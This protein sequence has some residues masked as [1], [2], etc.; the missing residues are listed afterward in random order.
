MSD[1][2]DSNNTK[3]TVL[4]VDDEPQVLEGMALHLRR[5]YIVTTAS[6]GADALRTL[7][8]NR[9]VAVIVSDMRMPEMDGATFLGRAKQV[10]PDAVRILLTG[11]AGLD[12]AV[13]AINHGQIFRFLTKPCAP[14]V[15]LAA[16][17]AATEQHRLIT[18]ERVLLEQTLHGTIKALTDLLALTDPIS[19]GRAVRVKQYVTDLARHLA[20]EERWQVE[21]AAMLSQLGCIVLPP[22][23][24]AKVYDGRTLTSE[25]QAMVARVPQVTDQLIGNIPRLESVRAI[26]TATHKSH[27]PLL[28]GEAHAATNLV[29]RGAHLLRAATDYDQLC[30]RG[31]PPGEAVSVMDGRTGRYAPYVL[32]ALRC[33]LADSAPP[34]R[35]LDVPASDLREGMV[36][37]DDLRLLAGVL[38]V[39][40]DTK[41]TAPFVERI[42][43]LPAGSIEPLIR[44]RVPLLAQA[45]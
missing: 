32:E 16:I 15:L 12:A 29:L 27:R 13:A 43:N 10:A 35:I 20:I 11:Q 22:D 2:N 31:A 36:M 14:P 4:C 17:D 6:S 21:V 1:T 42:R 33:L 41:L 18:A 24:V 26:L 3:P 37:V 19:F 23:T 30:T 40:R 39:T 8:T 25:E 44:V 38:L 28:E 9:S 34:E 5:R 45:S 7:G